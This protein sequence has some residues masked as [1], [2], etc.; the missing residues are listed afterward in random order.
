MGWGGISVI[1]FRWLLTLDIGNPGRVLPEMSV[2]H[3][4]QGEVLYVSFL[5]GKRWH[6]L[7]V[8]AVSRQGCLDFIMGSWTDMRPPS[9][10]MA[11][12]S[13]V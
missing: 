4:F 9:L 5:R 2:A 8:D 13:P 10:R 12:A 6:L 3:A 11:L 7:G 1:A